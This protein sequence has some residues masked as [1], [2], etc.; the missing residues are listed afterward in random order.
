M[1]MPAATET[2]VH[3][4]RILSASVMLHLPALLSER[5]QVEAKGQAAAPMLA[6][7][8]LWRDESQPRPPLKLPGRD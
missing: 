8:R 3:I 6:L 5:L 4:T 2:I 7:A 1:T